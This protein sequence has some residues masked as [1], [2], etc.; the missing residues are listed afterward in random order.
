MC[1]LR[2]GSFAF[3]MLVLALAEFAFGRGAMFPRLA[4]P[5][6]SKY[7]ASPGRVVLPLQRYLLLGERFRSYYLF[8]SVFTTL[9]PFDGFERVQKM[10]LCR[11]LAA[12]DFI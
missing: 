11:F 2:N 10:E 8:F 6:E 3:K 7:R 1:S 12:E 5:L 4:F 9:A